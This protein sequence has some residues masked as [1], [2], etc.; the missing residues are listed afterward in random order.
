MTA[1]TEERNTIRRD[2]V[3]FSFPV[4]AS[5]KVLTGTLVVLDGTTGFAEMATT[6]TAKVCVG[7][8]Q[9]TV[10]NTDGSAGDV[11]VPVRRGLFR[12]ANSTTTDEI[13]RADINATCYLVDNQ[14]VAKTHA[15]NT[16][17]A[18]GIVRDVDATGVWVEI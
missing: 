2:G 4:G 12:F 1:T 10:D 8:A 13:K 14:T 7:V 9:A 5:K 6:A 16:R 15:T 18:A 11:A 17:S 3:D